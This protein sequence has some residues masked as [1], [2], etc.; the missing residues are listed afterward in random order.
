MPGHTILPK[1]TA[2]S[3]LADGGGSLF[4]AYD[5][6]LSEAVAMALNASADPA[7]QPVEYTDYANGDP[8]YG[9]SNGVYIHLYDNGTLNCS[10]CQNP[11][12]LAEEDYALYT[13]WVSV[14]TYE[15]I[16]ISLN[17]IVFLTGII[18]NS[19]VR[20]TSQS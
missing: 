7:L 10:K 9:P 15:M 11:L 18:G 1:Q 5:Y 4:P 3:R 6:L 20:S 12:C 16:L 19:L 14:D 17:I 13:K 2:P 8:D